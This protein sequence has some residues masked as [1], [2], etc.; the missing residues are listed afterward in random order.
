M[1]ISSNF[2][3]Y[4]FCS[5]WSY[6]MMYG[7]FATTHSFSNTS[8]CTRLPRRFNPPNCKH[9]IWIYSSKEYPTNSLKML[10]FHSTTQQCLEQKE[11]FCYKWS[12]SLRI[13]ML[14]QNTFQFL[15]QYL[16][17]LVYNIQLQH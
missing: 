7:T 5:H 9:S 16:F 13:L 10:I 17:L 14:A 15:V 12:A 3:D 4:P 2:N 11:Y 6:I 8:L 1:N